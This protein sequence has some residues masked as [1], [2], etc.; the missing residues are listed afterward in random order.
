MAEPSD[1]TAGDPAFGRFYRQHHPEVLAY[2]RRRLSP[3]AAEDASA[4]VFA[5]A[6][7]K[8]AS[9]PQGADALPWLYGVAHR[10]VM[11]QWRSAFRYRRLADRLRRLA[12]PRALG[13]DHV[14]LRGVEAELARQALM[15]LREGDQ[16][17]LRLALWEELTPPEIAAVLGVN[18]QAVAMRF[19]RA[20]RRVGEKYRA[21]E[22]R[23]LAAPS[24]AR[25]GVID[26]QR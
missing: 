26:D 4:E 10:E 11:H 7:R 18:E 12:E 16:E 15:L 3:H 1:L 22:A 8:W 13:P 23:C 24:R 5:V 19:A 17:I 20:K 21:L 6:W 9:V 25:N 2:C 14:V